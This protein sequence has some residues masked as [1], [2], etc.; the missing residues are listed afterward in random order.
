[1]RLI[2][3]RHGE[4]KDNDAGILQG[5]LHGELNKSGI[6]QAEKVAVRLKNEKIDFIFTSDLKERQ[7]LQKL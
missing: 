6:E 5:Q 3:V 7:I 2:L 1:M 4:T